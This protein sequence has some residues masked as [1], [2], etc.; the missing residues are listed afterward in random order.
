MA[1]A[2]VEQD[3]GFLS[4]EQWAWFRG[5]ERAVQPV[6]VGQAGADAAGLG[7][8]PPRRVTSMGVQTPTL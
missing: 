4:G 5:V 8:L 7:W 2:D 6:A 1:E 3:F